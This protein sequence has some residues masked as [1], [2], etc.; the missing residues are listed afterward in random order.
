MLFATG[1]AAQPGATPAYPSKPVRW[2][3]PAQAGGANDTAARLIA[4]RLAELLGQT[5]VVDNRGGAGG[6][7]A[8]EVASKAQ[9]DGYT[10]AQVSTIQAMN[11]SFYRRL[12]YDLVR[13]LAPVI[14][15]ISVA[16]VIVVH[17]SVPVHTPQE[18]IAYAR[19]NPGKL[20]F[21]SG[22]NGATGHYLKHLAGID[23]EVVLYRGTPPAVTETVAGQSHV[24]VGT[25]SDLMPFARA[26]KLRALA[27]T[28]STRRSRA[29][30]IT[31][32][33]RSTGCPSPISRYC[34]SN[35]SGRTG[36]MRS[37]SRSSRA[38]SASSTSFSPS[39]PRSARKCS[40][41]LA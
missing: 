32:V 16:T 3:L 37:S 8:M 4:P 34:M 13:D 41:P 18:L 30:R 35:A 31:P 11:K 9:P 22:T 40:T 5:V 2:I 19:A 12:P 27:L 26:G 36:F 38:S 28:S 1:A 25:S 6:N 33:S 23:M 17:P 24:M 20:N 21:A 14:E 39:S 7:I 15:L 29:A 10:I